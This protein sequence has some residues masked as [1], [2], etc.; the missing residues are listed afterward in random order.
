MTQREN[1]PSTVPHRAVDV[2]V[3]ENDHA[4]LEVFVD[5]LRA[6]RFAVRGAANV[7]EAEA[8]MRERVPD[9]VLCD[10]HL[11]RSDSGWKLAESIRAN[12]RTCHVAR[13]AMTG[14]L[15]PTLAVVRSFDE[16]LRKPLNIWVLLET[17]A[18][19]AEASRRARLR[20]A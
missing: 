19:L 16:Y 4:T 20:V 17:V 12:P 18:R 9:V 2:L 11:D 8:A 14:H 5:L 13:I 10:L 15:H 6:N 3:V 1:A 7:P